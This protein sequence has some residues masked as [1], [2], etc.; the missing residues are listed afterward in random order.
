MAV[1]LRCLFVSK[2]KFQSRRLEWYQNL[3]AQVSV[4]PRGSV[5]LI[6]MST[7]SRKLWHFSSAILWVCLPLW[8]VLVLRL[9][10]I[11]I[12]I[13]LQEALRAS[14]YFLLDSQTC[15]R[16]KKEGRKREHGE[17]VSLLITIF[18]S[19]SGRLIVQIALILQL[20]LKPHPLWCELIIPLIVK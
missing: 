2:R 8:V 1:S 15:D 20:S 7:W 10:S 18:H 5:G 16:E 19:D 12:A 9:A 14:M 11:M 13:R 4:N 6:Q 3:L 17:K